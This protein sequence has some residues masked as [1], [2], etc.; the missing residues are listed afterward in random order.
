MIQHS[1]RYQAFLLIALIFAI[2]GNKCSFSSE[3]NESSTQLTGQSTLGYYL[4]YASLNNPAIEASYNRWQAMLEKI[5]QVKS[6]PDPRFSYGY[7][8][9]EIETRVGPQRYRFSVSQ[10]IPWLFKLDLQGKI[11]LRDALIAQCQ[12]DTLK[13]ALYAKVKTIFFKYAYL[14]REIAILNDM[15][16]L[17]DQ[18][19]SVTLTRY[20]SGTT[21]YADVLK[22]Q[23]E[24]SKLKDRLESARQM[25][26]PLMTE[27]NSLLNRPANI[28][29]T[30]P[31][32][33]PDKHKDFT[34]EEL[35]Q[36]LR[37]FNPQLAA[38]S[39]SIEKRKDMRN[40]AKQEFFPDVTIGL[41]YVQ[42]DN[43]IFHNVRDDGKDA[44]IGMVSVNVPIWW[45]KYSAG[46]REAEKNSTA[47]QHDFAETQNNLTT[48]LKSA[49]YEFHDAGRK[50]NLYNQELIPKAEQTLSTVRQAY[51]AGSADFFDLIDSYRTLLDFRLAYEKEFSR[52]FKS[53]AQIEMLSATDLMEY[54]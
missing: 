29:I 47:V 41:D 28:E 33:I 20:K 16:F 5:P 34:D 9:Q 36:A 43:S 31:D 46:I 50:M 2:V 42:T 15:V 53:L 39:V 45:N 13:L 11:A 35:F 49:L 27:F 38:V 23:I 12:Y 19:E 32:D 10:M 22:T 44:V 48:A 21:S 40:L 3:P 24:I 14:G 26:Q 8:F 54:D 7:Y 17:L 51:T 6:L 18:I 30:F 52:K 37:E 25:R 1:N 4:K